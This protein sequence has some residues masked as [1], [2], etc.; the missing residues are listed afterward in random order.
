MAFGNVY[1]RS[2]GLLVGL[3][4]KYL[5]VRA[6]FR[7]E[8]KRSCTAVRS[9]FRSPR[10]PLAVFSQVLELSLALTTTHAWAKKS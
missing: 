10:R 8:G 4:S 5:P 1:V 6:Q 3:R 9:T 2:S 7:P